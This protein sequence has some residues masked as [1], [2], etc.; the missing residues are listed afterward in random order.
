MRAKYCS[1]YNQWS[2]CR[3]GCRAASEQMGNT[4][5]KEDPIIEFMNLK[6]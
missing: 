6:R 5:E 3:G 1:K 2:K 4:I